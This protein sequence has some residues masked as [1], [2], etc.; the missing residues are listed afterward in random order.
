MDIS[1]N[2][3]KFIPTATQNCSIYV[4]IF[5]ISYKNSLNEM[6]DSYSKKR[7]KIYDMRHNVLVAILKRECKMMHV[8]V[9]Y[10]YLNIKILLFKFL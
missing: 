1:F 4:Q 2:K 10:A 9:Y 6:L 7:K 5:T 8:R 3:T